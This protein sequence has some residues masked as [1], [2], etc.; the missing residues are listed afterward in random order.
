MPAISISVPHKLDPD[1]AVRRLKNVVRD[2]QIQFADKIEKVE[3]SW[4]GNSATYSFDVMG[5]SISGTLRVAPGE[6]Q[7]EGNIPMAAL[8]FKSKIEILIREKMSQLLA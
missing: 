8:F 3:Q 2:L 5:F 4:T 7:L 6:A 1:E